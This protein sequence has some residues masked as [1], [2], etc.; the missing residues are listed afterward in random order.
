MRSGIKERLEENYIVNQT[1]ISL[2]TFK[3]VFCFFFKFRILCQEFWGVFQ[4]WGHLGFG[5]HL[6][7]ESEALFGL[8]QKQ[9]AS[10]PIFAL[11]AFCDYKR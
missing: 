6:G 2:N 9:A 5:E 1:K 4:T 11:L 8:S 7:E 3:I 10:S